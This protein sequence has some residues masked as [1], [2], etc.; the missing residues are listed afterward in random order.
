MLHP[1]EGTAT[2]DVPWSELDRLLEIP[3]SRSPGEWAT[4]LMHAGVDD[5]DTWLSESGHPLA[6]PDTFASQLHGFTHPQSGLHVEVRTPAGEDGDLSNPSLRYGALLLRA[7]V[8]DGDTSIGDIL[9]SLN[10]D[11]RGHLDLR[12]CDMSLRRRGSHDAA[13]QRDGYL[14]R[15][16]G[17][18]LQHHAER[19]LARYG[20]HR[21]SLNAVGV[22][23]YA[24]ATM[25]Y[26]F[27]P[28]S[29]H[30]GDA[31]RR[32][33]R[34]VTRILDGWQRKAPFLEQ[35]GQLPAQASRHISAAL[36]DS[37]LSTP[38]QLAMLDSDQPFR[39]PDGT[40]TWT[41]KV[42]MQ[43]VSWHGVKL[44]RPPA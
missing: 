8:M 22:G 34:V 30:Q 33:Q 31:Q 17:R 26:L 9:W 27:D 40:L 12:V 23:A 35:A 21:M 14:G 37:G 1:L 15:G 32:T 44:L 25:G 42:L 13:H 39:Q 19:T 4:A 28:R 43:D 6:D 41:G 36:G 5:P 2:L 10:R 18:A 7:D 20:V 38:H 3:T 16:F 11:E 24:W 29:V